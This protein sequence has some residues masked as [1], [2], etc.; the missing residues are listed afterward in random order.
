M[1]AELGLEAGSFTQEVGELVEHVWR[2][3]FGE[4]E[5][6]LSV[7]IYSIKLEQVTLFK[8]FGRNK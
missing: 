2:E 5:N 7:F 6:I 4:I 3:T 1:M 8:Y